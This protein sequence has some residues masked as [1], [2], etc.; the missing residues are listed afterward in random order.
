[1]QTAIDIVLQAGHSA[2]EVSLYTLLPIMVVMTI[3]L[4]I[5]EVTGILGWVMRWAAPVATPFGLTGLGIV[6][7]VQISLVS[8]VAPLPTLS[9]MED[10]G[11]SDRRLSDNVGRGATKL[12]RLICTI[13]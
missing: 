4:R 9:L 7:M 12:T 3:L 10:R 1:M 11:T 13:A 5:F 6:A 2:I 8:F